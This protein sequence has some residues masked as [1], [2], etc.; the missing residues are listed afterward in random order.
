MLRGVVHDIPVPDRGHVRDD[1]I[2]ILE[3]QLAVV[4]RDA[5]KLYPSL[6]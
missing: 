3:D 6:G 4:K 5:R 2:A 1:L